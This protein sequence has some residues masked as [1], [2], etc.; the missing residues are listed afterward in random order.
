V[1]L[2]EMYINVHNKTHVSYSE[3]SSKILMFLENLFTISNQL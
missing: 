3:Q 2:L 1:F